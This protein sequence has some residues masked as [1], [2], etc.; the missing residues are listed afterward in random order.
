M[1][2]RRKFSCADGTQ[3]EGETE[4][5]PLTRERVRER[6]SSRAKTSVARGAKKHVGAMTR[7]R[8]WRRRRELEN[9]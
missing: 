1:G 6:T 7:C 9:R 3:W 4:E 5:I 2:T 8:G